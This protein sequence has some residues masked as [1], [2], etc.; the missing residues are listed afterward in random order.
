MA[1]SFKNKARFRRI[2]KSL[3]ESAKVGLRV[4]L[5]EAARDI[6]ADQK[7]LCPVHTGALR[8]S[9]KA[10]PGNE[11][12]PAYATLR[13]SRSA[14]DPELVQILTAGNAHVR[15]GHLVEFGTSPH[16]NEGEFKGSDNPGAHAEPF[17]YPG[18]RA[19]KSRAKRQINTA[20]RQAI[21]DG[22]K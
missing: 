5:A 11:D 19:G 15:Y 14:S 10:T 6:V 13:S 22:I 1:S 8:D 21:K 7:N 18:F 9:I 4:A 2:L 17:F 20:A 12:L 16:V 3:P